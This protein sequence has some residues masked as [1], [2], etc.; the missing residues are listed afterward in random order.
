MIEEIAT[1][2]AADDSSLTLSADRKSACKG[3]SVSSSCGT[4]VLERFFN[5]RAVKPQ[6][7]IPLDSRYQVGECVVIGIEES[8]LSEV[9]YLS[10]W[11]PWL[12]CLSGWLVEHWF[13][14][15]PV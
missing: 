13:S 9:L 12:A 5:T 6:F 3:C 15:W 11:F 7:K 1:I 4:G 14:M 10:I 8:A 2:I